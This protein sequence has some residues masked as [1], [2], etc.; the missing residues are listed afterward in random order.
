LAVV[1]HVCVFFM[2]TVLLTV[3]LCFFQSH[4]IDLFSCIALPV[5]LINLL[6]LPVYIEVLSTMMAGDGEYGC[7][8]LLSQA[9][10]YRDAALCHPHNF[11]PPRVIFL[12]ST[13]VLCSISAALDS[14]GVYS[15]CLDRVLD[16]TS[17]LF[18]CSADKSEIPPS[19]SLPSS[20]P[21]SRPG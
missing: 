3:W 10:E 7:K 14:V 2:F 8:T 5:C 11:E 4:F 18:R 17:V 13:A 20:A 21:H 19:L 1:F 6:T 9:V 15:E 16:G 12:F